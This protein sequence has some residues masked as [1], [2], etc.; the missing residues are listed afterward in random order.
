M[1]IR[2]GRLLTAVCAALGA[3]ATR[4]GDTLTTRAGDR[5]IPR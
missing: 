3:L 4:S 1:L 5:L 2:I